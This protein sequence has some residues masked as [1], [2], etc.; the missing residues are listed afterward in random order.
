MNS[1]FSTMNNTKKNFISSM[2]Y[3]IIDNYNWTTSLGYYIYYKTGLKN[4]SKKVLKY[5]NDTYMKSQISK[6]NKGID[7][8]VTIFQS[9]KSSASKKPIKDMSD[10]TN[11]IIQEKEGNSIKLSKKY[12]FTGINPYNDMNLPDNISDEVYKNMIY[13]RSQFSKKEFSKFQYSFPKDFVI[14]QI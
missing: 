5:V 9:K 11:V 8:D 1:N 10:N 7:I 6:I 12:K 3:H 14:S 4:P 2:I 13:M